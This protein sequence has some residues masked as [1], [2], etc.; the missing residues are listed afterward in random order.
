MEETQNE[1]ELIITKA[2]FDNELALKKYNFAKKM[3]NSKKKSFD[4]TEQKYFA[5]TVSF[6]DYKLS[7][8]ELYN[9][10][11]ELIQ[12]KYE[13]LLKSVILNFYIDKNS[14]F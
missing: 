10:T 11:N 6:Y 8:T 14:F 7:K 13:Y 12:A 2:Y 1:I 3:F 9:A 5:G 4:N